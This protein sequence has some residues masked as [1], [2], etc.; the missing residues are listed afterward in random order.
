MKLFAFRQPTFLMGGGLLWLMTF[1]PLVAMGMEWNVNSTNRFAW[2][3]HTD[4]LAVPT[5]ETGLRAVID[6]SG[7][8][9]TGLTWS[10]SIGWISFGN[11]NG[12][13]YLNTAATNWG[14]NLDENWHLSGW[15][16]GPNVGWILFNDAEAECRIEP[17]SG[18]LDGWG[19]SEQIGWIRWGSDSGE[20]LTYGVQFEVGDLRWIELSGDLAFR[21]VLTGPVSNRPIVIAN[22]GN[23]DLTIHSIDYPAGFSGDWAGGVLP[24]GGTQTVWVAFSPVLPQEYGGAVTVHSDAS[25][26]VS[27]RV[28]S[29]TGIAAYILEIQPTSTN[30]PTAVSTGHMLEVSANMDW[31]ASTTSEWLSITA[32]ETGSGTG[33]IWF[34][35]AESSLEETRAGTIRVG[36]GDLVRTCTVVQ[37]GSRQPQFLGITASNRYAWSSHTGWLAV[38]TN[39]WGL[40]A[41]LAETGWFLTGLAW[42]DSIGWIS[43]GNTN[44]G[45]YANT[46]AVDWGVNLNEQWELSGWAWG[47][48]VGWISFDASPGC[49]IHP[50]RGMLDGWAR[51]EQI[52]WIR[53]GSAATN[54]EE[55]LAY[56]VQLDLS[57]GAY[58]V[59]VWWLEWHGVSSNQ[60]DQV[61]PAFFEGTDPFDPA[62][63]LAILALGTEET[64]P[65]L[66]F[67]SVAGR[68]YRLAASSN[69]VDWLP[70]GQV[71][72]TGNP[73]TYSYP[74]N[75]LRQHYRLSVGLDP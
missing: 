31:A 11:T 58:Q 50:Q 19:R 32:G 33:T 49:R 66:S 59:P 54:E 62:A 40:Q 15:A 38:P 60:L 35:V 29:G 53:W 73:I 34:D 55:Q 51:S 10:D 24:V 3:S 63:R 47:P 71:S 74:T 5:N 18:R 57:L 46:S 27:N 26:G 68:V 44:G 36:G 12:G 56:G 64:G 48:N 9:L 75:A 67:D 42:S 20:P 16:W 23:Q 41:V 14:V 6:E 39:E 22:A 25:G 37:A 30:V 13:P 2:S 17:A 4:W 72:G 7:S 61:W 52:G 69:L 1:F 43:F 8:F 28:V 65:Y 21:S 70:A 45:Q